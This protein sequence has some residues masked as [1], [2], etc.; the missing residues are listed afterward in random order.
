[1]PE[2]LLSLP[3][4]AT[5]A[6]SLAWCKARLEGAL[7]RKKGCIPGSLFQCPTLERRTQK[8]FSQMSALTTCFRRGHSLLCLL[9]LWHYARGSSRGRM[10]RGR[11]STALKHSG[12]DTPL[13]KTSRARV[14][15]LSYTTAKRG[16]FSV[17]C[18]SGIQSY[19]CICQAPSL[20]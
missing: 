5:A 9:K 1:M 11:Q 17:F 18:D 8:C 12:E 13:G 6:P 14:P 19:T 15:A 2:V 3:R 4:M 20:F 10:K 16:V 7:L